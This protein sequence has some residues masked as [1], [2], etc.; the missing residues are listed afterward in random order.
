MFIVM[1]W[2]PIGLPLLIAAVATLPE[3]Q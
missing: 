3:A 1:G 2:S